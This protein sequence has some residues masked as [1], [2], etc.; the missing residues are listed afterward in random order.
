MPK[1]N[2]QVALITGASRGIGRC[3]ALRLAALKATVVLA[4]RNKDRLEAAAKEAEEAGGRAIVVPVE[5][6]N[7][8]SIKALAQTVHDRL[9]RLDVLVNNAGITYSALLQETATEDYDRLMRV[10]ARAP[11][12]LCRETLDL[13]KKAPRGRIVN[14][15]SVVGAKGYPRQSAYTAS[16]HALRGMSIALA[17]ELRDTNV[18]VHVICPGGVDTDMVGDVRPDI[19]K[20]DLIAPDEIAELVE[21]L[22]THKG[23]AVVD[24]LRPRRRTAAPWF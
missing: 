19:D 15:A 22:V 23:N 18:R 16:K 1:L 5:L 20:G 8:Q 6:E 2:G 12:I 4:A 3:I 17:E 7:E 10:N 24:E 21:Y 11:F 14:I 13:L 9:A